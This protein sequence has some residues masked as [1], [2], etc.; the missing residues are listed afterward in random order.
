MSDLCSVWKDQADGVNPL[1]VRTATNSRKYR[2]FFFNSKMVQSS[3]GLNLEEKSNL[4]SEQKSESARSAPSMDS[5]RVCPGVQLISS[6][7]AQPV[8]A[9]YCLAFNVFPGSVGV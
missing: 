8:P 2:L 9:K 1:T 7:R 6:H 5:S 4:R 3:E